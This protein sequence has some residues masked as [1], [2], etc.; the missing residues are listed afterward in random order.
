VTYGNTFVVYNTRRSRQEGR[1]DSK[2]PILAF[3]DGLREAHETR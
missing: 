2:M 1:K 3:I